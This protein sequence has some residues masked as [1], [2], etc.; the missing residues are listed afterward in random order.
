MAGPQRCTAFGEVQ[1]LLRGRAHAPE[2]PRPA[3]GDL[4]CSTYLAMRG[5]LTA[6]CL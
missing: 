2:L 5:V 4:L 1:R 3:Q 6:P